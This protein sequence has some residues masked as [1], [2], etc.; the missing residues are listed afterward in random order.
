MSF[1]TLWF[2]L[3]AV[4]WS[5]YFVLEGFDFG[6]GMLLP[7]LARDEGDREA[8]L[9][10]I[11][12]VWDGNEVWL[13]VAGGATFAAFPAWYATVFSGFYLALLAVLVC[14]ILRVVSFEWRGKGESTRWRRF[15]TWANAIGSAGAA[16]IWG[17]AVANFLAGVPLDPAG[18]FSGTVLDLFTPY[19][20]FAGL[21]FVL[22][23]L[24]HGANFLAL[25]AVG[26][27]GERAGE[28]ARRL[29]APGAVAGIALMGWSVATAVD[30]NARGPLGPLIPA[31][32]GSLALGGAAFA[33]AARRPGLAFTLG[34]GGI[35]AATAT[36]FTGLYPRVLVSSTG[37]SNSLTTANASSSHYALAV[38]SV[39]ALLALPVVLVY[40]SWSY[41]VF[42]H[43]VSA[44][45]FEG[46]TTPV[47]AVRRAAERRDADHP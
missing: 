9:N 11:G 40:Q 20:V 36:I 17:V 26:E 37:F 23:F 19:T 41:W 6:V 16:L 15:W 22:L 27:L 4:L 35:L 21:A 46:V 28:T 2:V 42:R 44:R 12:P 5:G 47:A 29:A 38:I 30:A 39:V 31:L 34:A 18:E 8:M 1:Q 33:A 32:L 24:F 25:R 3:I 14:L 7:F 13:V 10:A 45:G 43:R